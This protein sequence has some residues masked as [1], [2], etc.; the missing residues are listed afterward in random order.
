M[1]TRNK[2]YN[3]LRSLT[4]E[5]KTLDWR[6]EAFEGLRETSLEVSVD[7][8]HGYSMAT[9]RQM[10]RKGGLARAKKLTPKQRSEAARRA[11]LVRW[12]KT[13]RRA[14]GPVAK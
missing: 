13:K 7:A 10:A 6:I 2:I 14:G 8:P 12:E 5:L 9:I 1:L 11:V 3:Y 4:E